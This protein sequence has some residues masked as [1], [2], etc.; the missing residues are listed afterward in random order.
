[1]SDRNLS[2][3][4]RALFGLRSLIMNGE[5]SSGQRLSE[6]AV[7]KMLGTSRTPLRQAMDRLVAE[8]LLVRIE[9]GGC[10]VATFTRADIADAIEIR[11]VI[12]GTAARMAAQRGVSTELLTQIADTLD[13][14]DRAINDPGGINFDCYVKRNA[15]FHALLAK[16]SGSDLIRSE[17]ERV[18]LLPLASPSAFLIEQAAIPDFLDSLRYAQRQHRAILEAI[19]NRECARAEALVREHAR[20]ALINFNYLTDDQ[21]TLINN[22]PGLTLVASK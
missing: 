16:C 10:R 12:E 13:G 22:V 7:A 21:P 1:M 18:S 5:F 11:G 2:Q 8:G 15:E 14:I 6:V 20:L 17:I 9:T 3:L 4:D 19:T